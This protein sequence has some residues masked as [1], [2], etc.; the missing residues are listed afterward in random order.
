MRAVLCCTGL[1]LFV[2]TF[3]AAAESTPRQNWGLSYGYQGLA[4]RKNLSEN[5]LAYLGV[6]YGKSNLET[7]STSSNA[8]LL[9]NS[10]TSSNRTYTASIGARYYLANEKLSDF[11]QIELD[12]SYSNVD[13]ITSTRSHSATLGYGL[14][15]YLEPLVSV[16]ARAG[17]RY[18]YSKIETYLTSSSTRNT[19]IPVVGI[20]ITRYW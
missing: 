6:N 17:V 19:S 5:T 11:V 16:E 3:P 9:S 14:E 10:G 18:T 8:I 7:H 1:M 15:Y 13:S 20:A 12:E 4:I 2:F